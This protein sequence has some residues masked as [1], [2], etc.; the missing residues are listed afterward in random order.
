[1]DKLYESFLR[2]L[3]ILQD[4][5]MRSIA[6]DID[7]SNRILYIRGARGVG[8]TTL[9]LQY[10]KNNFSLN[11]EVLY[12]SLDDIVFSEISLLELADK[13]C[14]NN[15]KYLF[16]D[17][18]HKYP[19]W[20]Q[21][22]KNIYDSY[23]SLKI[24]F[25]GSSSLKI[26][27]GQVDLSRRVVEYKMPGLSFR[28]F[29]NYTHTF[30][31]NPITLYELLTNHIEI[32]STV[33]KK[34]KPLVEFK[35][36]CKYGYYPFFMENI[37]SYNQKLNNI[38]NLVLE[39][40]IPI[41]NEL[42]TQHIVK[43]KKLLY[44]IANSVPFKPNIVKLSEKLE[45]SRNTVLMYLDFLEKAEIIHLLYPPVTSLGFLTK[46][47][48]IYLNNSNLNHVLSQELKDLGNV[49][50]TFF[51]NQLSV[52]HKVNYTETGDFLVD[53]KYTFEVGG[54]NKTTQQIRRIPNSYIASDEIEY[55]YKN[56]IPLWLMGFLY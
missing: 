30:F 25:T 27:Q 16:V 44:V 43:I 4:S 51:M 48:K 24:V 53:K 34:I 54:K 15:G 28:E 32:S 23:P 1:M 17:E 19:N 41:S 21:E 18:I 36:Y 31:L 5:T 38:V 13:F 29:L 20:A 47:D 11:E 26:H 33:N 6:K 12:I 40:D 14:K 35:K 8:K 22:L 39:S 49:R 7:W 46:P 52:K 9:L 56:R 45:I 55:G 2:R 42:K 3:D 10:I 50:E 37:R